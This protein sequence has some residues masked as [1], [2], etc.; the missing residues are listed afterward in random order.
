M[1]ELL[2]LA[3]QSKTIRT[4][5]EVEAA[6]D[7]RLGKGVA[8]ALRARL[9]DLDAAASIAEVIAGHPRLNPRTQKYIIGLAAG[10]VLTISANHVKNPMDN[11]GRIRWDSVTR[12][13]VDA[14]GEGN[15]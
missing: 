5:C 7:K 13:K 8:A 15:D 12:I 4:L 3:F 2:E 14:I 11:S 10:F 6:A 9:A 1:E